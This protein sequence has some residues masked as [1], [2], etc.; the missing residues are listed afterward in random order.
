MTPKEIA[1]QMKPADPETLN[2]PTEFAHDVS[3]IMK[4]AYL[5]PEE[6]KLRF[7]DVGG[8]SVTDC[9]GMGY[10]RYD[11]EKMVNLLRDETV[12]KI[13]CSKNTIYFLW[14]V[15]ELIKA[16]EEIKSGDIDVQLISYRIEKALYKISRF[17]EKEVENGT[18]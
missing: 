2:L 6:I 7:G 14:A 1:E 18:A 17:I 8:E 11:H 4:Y 16:R 13:I 3:D 12:Q 5:S 9:N 15:S 10:H